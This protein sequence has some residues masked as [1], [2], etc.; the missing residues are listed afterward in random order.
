MFKSIIQHQR[1]RYRY[2][3]NILTSMSHT[4]VNHPT[5]VT[6]TDTDTGERT[7]INPLIKNVCEFVESIKNNDTDC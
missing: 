6:F 7:T 3:S 5:I 4:S 1:D 2:T